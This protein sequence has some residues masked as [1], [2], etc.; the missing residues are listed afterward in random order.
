MKRRAMR[1]PGKGTARGWNP[2]PRGGVALVKPTKKKISPRAKRG[3]AKPLRFRRLT[4]AEVVAFEAEGLPSMSEAI[5]AKWLAIPEPE[6]HRRLRAL[7]EAKLSE[8]AAGVERDRRALDGERRRIAL[9]EL[10][11]AL[12]WL[13]VERRAVLAFKD[14][15]L[16]KAEGE[17]EAESLERT[18]ADL[19]SAND[20]E[21]E[22]LAC[23]DAARALTV[24]IEGLKKRREQASAHHAAEKLRCEWRDGEWPRTHAL[25]ALGWTLGIE[26]E[27]APAMVVGAVQ[28][29]AHVRAMDGPA[30][31]ARAVVASLTGLSER[32]IEGAPERNAAARATAYLDW[33]HGGGRERG[34][35]G[36]LAATDDDGLEK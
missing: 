36:L 26:P 10:E 24:A 22:L 1:Y 12:A 17:R 15:A 19:E 8:I 27:E 34:R 21:L 35:L 29:K 9:L 20:W 32:T 2:E 28:D 4:D 33:C 31:G 6:R 30:K 3:K 5:R 7:M 13:D 25:V 18:L 23:A 11:C 16:A 14:D